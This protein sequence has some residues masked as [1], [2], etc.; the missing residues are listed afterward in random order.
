MKLNDPQ[1]ALA[2]SH[3]GFLSSIVAGAD[4]QDGMQP[5]GDYLTL[6]QLSIGLNWVV[7]AYSSYRKNYEEDI[8]AKLDRAREEMDEL[9]AS[10][11]IESVKLRS[12]LH[13]YEIKQISDRELSRYLVDATIR[14]H[15]RRQ[16]FRRRDGYLEPLLFP[17]GL[18]SLLALCY[19][20]FWPRTLV[21]RGAIY[22]ACAI[23]LLPAIAALA[24]L[25]VEVSQHERAYRRDTRGSYI[26]ASEAGQDKRIRS[27]PLRGEIAR[28]INQVRVRSRAARD[29]SR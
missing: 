10:G 18:L 17:I 27:S 6:L 7:G 23:G 15:R 9:L 3:I 14:F 1:R 4:E 19:A 26:Q 16:K 8:R 11:E 29:A 21:S 20:S 2:C 12:N 25:L 28:I 24:R 5:I 22:G 13:D